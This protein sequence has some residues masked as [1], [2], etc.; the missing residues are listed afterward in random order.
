MRSHRRLSLATTTLLATL[1]MS[2]IGMGPA[3]AGVDDV[4]T[5]RVKV[6]SVALDGYTGNLV[7]KAGVKCTRQVKGVGTASWNV[8]AVQDLRAQATEQIRC[9]GVR[10]R[11]ILQLD[12]K[13]GR[14]HSGLVNL[15]LTVTRIGSTF[16]EADSRSFD[17]VV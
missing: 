2:G 3:F 9:D 16:A 5:A 6:R 1:S 17:T 11:S 13:R 14:F 8:K 15:T 4:P 10:H 12:P 7:V